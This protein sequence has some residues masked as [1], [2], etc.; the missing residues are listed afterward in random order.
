MPEL[1]NGAAGCPLDQELV[2]TYIAKCGYFWPEFFDKGAF[3]Y[4]EVRFCAFQRELEADNQQEA[5]RIVAQMNEQ[6]TC[7]L[8]GKRGK[9]RAVTNFDLMN[10]KRILDGIVNNALNGR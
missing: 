4:S 8:C 1:E 6:M 3:V 10:E 9:F 5:E 7:P 2:P